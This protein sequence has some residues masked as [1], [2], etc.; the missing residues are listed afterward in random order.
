MSYFNDLINL[1]SDTSSLGIILELLFVTSCIST[2]IFILTKN[3]YISLLSSAPIFFMF[4]YLFFYKSH[5]MLLI[6]AMSVQ[7]LV[8]ILIQK[9]SN[10]DT[11]DS[12][13]KIIDEEKS[14]IN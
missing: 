3:E 14:R 6:L 7:V 2:I 1:I 12:P 8:I 5:L 13:L 10:Q 4:S 9:M 11:N